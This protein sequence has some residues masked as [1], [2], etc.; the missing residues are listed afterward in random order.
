MSSFAKESLDAHNRY[1]ASH[2][3]PAMKWSDSMAK[4]AEEWAK[5]LA[6]EGKLKHATP[7]ERKTTAKMF[8]PR[9]AKMTSLE[10]K[11]LIFGIQKFPNMTSRRVRNWL[12][13]CERT[14]SE[15]WTGFWHFLGIKIK[16]QLQSGG[17][18]LSWG[19][20]HYI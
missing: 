7:A 4:E 3:S 19:V 9:Q 13:C 11:L 12:W 1:R 8:M 6:K 17:L 5:K 14:R 18:E 16:K 2:G 10:A 15:E 20:L